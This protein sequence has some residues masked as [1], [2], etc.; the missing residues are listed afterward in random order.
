MII[1]TLVLIVE[2]LSLSFWI[3]GSSVLLLVV[4]PGVVS[5]PFG[6]QRAGD[7][8][9]TIVMK[10]RRLLF[11]LLLIMLLCLLGQLFALNASVGFKLRLSIGFVTAAVLLESYN[12]F[13]LMPLA[14]RIASLEQPT[15]EEKR[16]FR[17]RWT[18]SL[19][20]L[21]LNLFLGV[22]VVI[23]LITPSL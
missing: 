6:E 9:S 19:R 16:E 12:R 2:V 17:E 10:F 7:L 1:S 11:P 21:T 18:R 4:L 13:R 8:V 14:L 15:S 22:A 5:L 20:I 23:S 3:G